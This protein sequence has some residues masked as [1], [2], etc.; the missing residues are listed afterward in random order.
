MHIY[1]FFTFCVCILCYTFW[2]EFPFQAIG[3]SFSMMVQ[4]ICQ[5]HRGRFDGYSCFGLSS[6]GQK[7]WEITTTNGTKGIELQNVFNERSWGPVRA[8]H[9]IRIIWPTRV[10]C[11]CVPWVWDALEVLFHHRSWRAFQFAS[12]FNDLPDAEFSEVQCPPS[13]CFLVGPVYVICS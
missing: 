11:R 5:G 13:H 8:V 4:H 9:T 10:A 3:H 1:V 2:C 7:S 6:R 12:Q